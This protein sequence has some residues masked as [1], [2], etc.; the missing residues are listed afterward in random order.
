MFQYLEIDS[1]RMLEWIFHREMERLEQE[2]KMQELEEL[3]RKVGNVIYMSGKYKKNCKCKNRK[4]NLMKI[5][6]YIGMFKEFVFLCLFSPFFLLSMNL[7]WQ[8]DHVVHRLGSNFFCFIWIYLCV[9]STKVL[10]WPI[11]KLDLCI[12][13]S[14][15]NSNYIEILRV[16]FRY[17]TKLSAVH[18]C[19]EL[20]ATHDQ[21]PETCS[22]LACDTIAQ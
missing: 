5:W 22:Q 3:K 7:K 10:L 16:T 1:V 6:F 11:F 9:S 13:T 20:L 8:R 21:F 4:L 18:I 14:L 2:R 12:F 17:N 19:T 15:F